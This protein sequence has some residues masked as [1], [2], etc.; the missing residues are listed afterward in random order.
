MG[1]FWNNWE[2]WILM[3]PQYHLLI[4][5]MVAAALWLLIKIYQKVK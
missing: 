2:F 4:L 5:L 1:A 3:A